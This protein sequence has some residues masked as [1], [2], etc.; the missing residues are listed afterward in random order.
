MSELRTS[1]VMG[2]LGTGFVGSTILVHW[3]VLER[4]GWVASKIKR[5]FEARGR[6]EEGKRGRGEE[7]KRGRGEEGKRGRGEEGKRGGTEERR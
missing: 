4:L 7:G 1:D 2:S 3:L 6:G 5:L